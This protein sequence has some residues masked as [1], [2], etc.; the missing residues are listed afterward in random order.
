[1]RHS[2]DRGVNLW[3]AA[4]AAISLAL[5]GVAIL[6]VTRSTADD[7]WVDHTH[8]VIHCLER[9]FSLIKDV[10]SA[11]R[12]FVVVGEE[13]FLEPRE[14]ALPRIDQDLRS[15]ETLTADNPAQLA[16]L[17]ALRQAIKTKLDFVA[18]AIATRRASGLDAVLEL[19]KNERGLKLMEDIRS[20]VDEMTA[21]EL[22]LLELRGRSA[23]EGRAYSI[24][25]LS[26]GLT[27][28]L[29]ILAMLFHQIGR[30]MKRRGR[31]EE[32]LKASEAE[33]RKL[34]LVASRSHNLVMITDAS[35]RIEWV[36]EAFTRMTGYSPEEAIGRDPVELL[37]GPADR[38]ITAGEVWDSGRDGQMLRHEVPQFDK[39]GRRSWVAAEVQQVRDESG[40]VVQHIAVGVDITAR[41][42]AEARLAVQHASTRILSEAASLEGAMPELRA[43][44]GR[45]LDVDVVE[46][47]SYDAPSGM[48]QAAG[49]WTSSEAL[50]SSFVSPSAGIRFAPDEGLPGR[51][52]SSG[53]S[54]WIDDLTGDPSFQRRS[55]AEGAGLR[56]AFGFPIASESGPIGVVVMLARESQP[57]DE[58]LLAVLNSLGQQ[59]GLFVDRKLGENALRESE[60]RF[61]TLADGTPVMIWEG[62]PD[63]RRSWFNRGWLDFTGFTMEDQLGSGWCRL[64]HPD[65]LERLLGAIE[66]S[67]RRVE[68][69]RLE[70][71]LRRKDGQYRW[72]LGKALPR[73]QP[74]G[75]F[76]GFIGCC[77]DV[78]E[79]RAASE[80][81][82]SASRAKSD[83]L[84]NMSHEIRTPMNGI[85]GMTELAMET[86]L[87]PRQRE[88]LG[89]VRSSA[90]ALL[91][92]IND[93]LDF[94]KIEA[95]KLDLDP[96]PF[97]IRESLDDT[98]R[99]L[100]QRAHAKELELACRIAPDVPDDLI[101]D[102]GRLRQVIVN[103]VGNAIKFTERGE[104]VVSVEREPSP[105]SEVLLSISVADTGIGIPAEKRR[106]IFAPFE[107]ADG[108]T[109][110]RYGG[111]GLGL[112]ISSKLVAMMGGEI[113]V[114]GEVGRGSIFRFTARFGLGVPTP[115]RSG[116]GGS[117]P[118]SG[119]RVL[120]VDD[121]HTNRRILEEVLL[122]WGAIPSLVEHAEA[123]LVALRAASL[124]G[125]PFE[126]ALIDGMMPEMDGFDLAGA[127]RRE[128]SLVPPLMVMLTSG[129]Q[130]GES[131]RA[132]ALG[133]SAYLTKPVRQ[134]ELFDSL[135]KILDA[136]ST[137]PSGG[138][139]PE[140]APEPVE[141]PSP[142]LGSGLRILLAE[143]HVVNQKVAVCI[144]KGMGHET[145]VA[146]NGRIAVD[147]WKSSPFD[148]ILM[149]VQMPEM[150]G[151]EAVAAIRAEEARSGG[152][153]PI[154][155]V[156][157][158]AMKG[159]RDRCL[160][161]GFDDYLSKPIRSEDLRK[162]IERITQARPGE[163]ETPE[164]A[165]ETLTPAEFDRAAALDGLGGDEQLL[166]EVV[167]LF[168]DDCPRLLAEIDD[169]IRR[170]DDGTV[171]RLAHTVR[172][173]ASN[174][175]TPAVVEAARNLEDKGRIADWDGAQAAFDGLRRSID[176][177][178]PALG[179]LVAASAN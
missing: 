23:S 176:R 138:G 135:M 166:G 64:I 80:A 143:D 11:A 34:A 129:G 155:A 66:A 43:A 49:S 142:V 165:P 151:F 15:L 56:H 2:L 20:K 1:M 79:L 161:S 112:A 117:S 35:H 171:K 83:F 5:G 46:Y 90:E 119:L 114:D 133:I 29:A 144:L 125:H 109:T 156:T 81:A 122:G 85:L 102:P 60:A 154:M 65:D 57:A 91:T 170:A 111:T 8:V 99:T 131:E 67:A 25:V 167:G 87:S 120:V 38:P 14:N 108:S 145:T 33:S 17:V 107:Q 127:I 140:T 71:R 128:T 78:T 153:I 168:L 26:L 163:A 118:I 148:L 98:I 69:C 86:Q 63:G 77:L 48:L 12:G 27:A 93:I 100:A 110:R 146:D 113:G 37:G 30:E 40:A 177:V 68:E 94:S 88:Y 62:E 31:A 39:W 172:G 89:L 130:S 21:H 3:F 179:A 164:S 16:R 76:G 28:N 55:L 124:G 54:A 123:A 74:D 103:L 4:V 6:T 9:T 42:S 73:K 13:K 126:V 101:G 137:A 75:G 10:E 82:E 22:R 159:D 41:R 92:V 104:V 97:A 52:W 121:N 150:D 134:S 45:H 147:A 115:R 178:R 106:S 7:A 169:A 18:L 32:A 47:W 50:A 105:E 36:N 157:A 160:A 24:L 173:V 158:H 58:A 95:G 70:Y 84:A 59:I 175:A 53:Q 19:G 116:Q 136:S 132:R 149:D 174:F 141:A 162:A 152:H 139:S 51:V 61:R 44:I 72:I 96:I